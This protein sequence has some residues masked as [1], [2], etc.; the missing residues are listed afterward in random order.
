MDVKTQIMMQ[1]WVEFACTC[2]GSMD[3]E[4]EDNKGDNDS[5]SETSSFP[6]TKKDKQQYYGAYQIFDRDERHFRRSTRDNNFI[7]G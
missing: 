4:S 5:K 3:P 7:G 1:V 6:F 2:F